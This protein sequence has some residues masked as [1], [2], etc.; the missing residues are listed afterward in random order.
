MHIPFSESNSSVLDGGLNVHR[1]HKFGFN[2]KTSILN[3][4]VFS[5]GKHEDLLEGKMKRSDL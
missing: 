3:S 4:W 1:V 2:N 5:P